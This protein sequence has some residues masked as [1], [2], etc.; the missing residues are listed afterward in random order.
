M[1]RG[2]YGEA[3]GVFEPFSAGVASFKRRKAR[4]GASYAV[5]SRTASPSS[6][7]II[8]DLPYSLSLVSGEADRALVL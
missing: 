7:D 2:P 8:M 1:E 5:R 3:A 6:F 4:P